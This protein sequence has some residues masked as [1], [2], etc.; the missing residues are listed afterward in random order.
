M[1]KDQ[2]VPKFSLPPGVKGLIRGRIPNHP[3]APSITSTMPFHALDNIVSFWE[4]DII[5]AHFD[6]LAAIF[7]KPLN[8]NVIL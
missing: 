5:P 6:H 7:Y 8:I 1:V 4:A 2:R 3:L